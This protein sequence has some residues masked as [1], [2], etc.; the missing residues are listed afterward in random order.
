MSTEFS[1]DYI[2]SIEAFLRSRGNF[3]ALLA[4]DNI[5]LDQDLSPE[6]QTSNIRRT[7][8]GALKNEQQT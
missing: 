5:V 7:I 8:E 4:L 2:F 6:E 1:P 3:K